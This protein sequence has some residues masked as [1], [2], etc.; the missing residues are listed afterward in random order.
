MSHTKPVYKKDTRTRYYVSPVKVIWQSDNSA[1]AAVEQSEKLLEERDS[2]ATHRPQHPCIMRNYS[3]EASILLDFGRQL[4]GG[5]NITVWSCGRQ[6]AKGK[7]R[8]RFGESAMEAMSELKGERN[9]TN[10]HAI[11]DQVIEISSLGHT[12][13]GN[14][15]FRFV[16]I[17]LLGENCFAEL[18]SVRA[19]HLIRDLDYAGSFRSNDALLNEIWQTGAY[20]VHLNM[21]DYLWDGIKRDRLVWIGDMHPETSTIQAVFGYHDIVPQSLDLVREDTPL[22]NWMNHMPPYSIWWILIQHDW[23]RQNGDLAY[24][25]EQKEYLLGLIH[26]L[27]QFIDKDGRNTIPNP[28]LDWPS[29]PNKAAVKAGVHALFTMAMDKA[30]LMFNALGEEEAQR[31]CEAA[32][33]KL[34]TYKPDH[35]NNKQAAGLMVLAGLLDAKTAEQDVIGKDGAHGLST[36]LGYYTLQALAQAGKIE[37]SLDIIREYWGGML[38]LGATTFWEHFDLKWMENASRIDE[39]TPPGKKDVHGENGDYCY[40]GYRHSLCHGWASGPTAWLSQYVLG[41]HLV[42]PGCKTIRIDPQLGDLEWVE[43]TYP[44]PFGIISLRHERQDDGT[45]RSEVQAPPEIT[46]VRSDKVDL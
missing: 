8:V 20:T 9:A 28:F 26:Q 3:G 27:H 24:L 25:R 39:L 16:R 11:R 1:E 29:S 42:E 38:A 15:G 22:P 13:I 21:Q 14:T 32:A 23:Y 44:T 5:V 10:D 2:Q 34:R 6:L 40:V 43:G 12:E 41:V 19:V 45:I 33:A 17:D 18:K 37:K 36:F 31:H 30:A 35:G 46:I 7:F 4:H